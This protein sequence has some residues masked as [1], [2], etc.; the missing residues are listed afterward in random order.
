MKNTK[1][2]NNLKKTWIFTIAVLILFSFI[3]CSNIFQ[4]SHSEPEQKNSSDGK[5]YLVVDNATIRK[6]TSANRAASGNLGPNSNQIDVSK[7]TDFVLKGRIQS[8]GSEM[9]ELATA[10]TL[11]ELKSK[12]IMVEPA[13]WELILYTKLDGIPFHGTTY[14]TIEDGKENKIHFV[15]VADVDYGKLE[16]TVEWTNQASKV[17]AWLMD[18]ATQQT[19]IAHKV[20]TTFDSVQL[21]ESDGTTTAGHKVSFSFDKDINGQNLA[22]GTYYL[23]VDFDDV[24]DS[25]INK[26]EYFVNIAKGLTTKTTVR[27]DLSP[28]YSIT[29]N[30]GG[31]TLVGT[32]KPMNYNRRS[33]IILPE[34]KS[35]SKFFDGWYDEDGNKITGPIYGYSK[36]GPLTFTAQWKNPVLYVSGTGDDPTG[37]G[38]EANPYESIDKACETI[39][40]TGESEMDWVIYIMG[41]VTGPYRQNL[42]TNELSNPRKAGQ[43]MYDRDFGRSIIPE[44]LTTEHAKSIL[45]TGY[46]TPSTVNDYPQDIINRGL[47]EVSTYNGAG[48][49]LSIITQVP[50]TIT[51]VKLTNARN[52]DTN[53]N[54]AN[55]S[56]YNLGGG[57]G[58]GENATVYLGDN[59]YIEHNK[60]TYG[61]GIYNAGT[62]YI[63]GSAC[64]GDKTIQTVAD[65]YVNQ[66]DT[67]TGCFRSSNEYSQGGGIYNKG[68]LYLGYTRYVSATDND[69][70]L[71]TGGIYRSYGTTGGGIYITNNSTVVMN[72][73][74]IAYN[75]GV[76]SA[77][78]VY[79]DS[80]TFI[81]TGGTICHNST[82]GTGG[83]VKVD[84]N[85]VFYFGVEDPSDNPAIIGPNISANWATGNGGGIYIEGNSSTSRGKVFMFGKAVVGDK[86]KNT[87]P[88]S[89]NNANL[90]DGQNATNGGGGGIYVAGNLYMGYTRYNSGS[91]FVTSELNGGI[92]YNYTN[93]TSASSAGGGGIFL[94]DNGK[95]LMNSG[96]IANNVATKK[97]DALYVGGKGFVLGGTATI[98]AG[99]TNQTIYVL[100]NNFYLYIDNALAHVSNGS[101]RL[102]PQDNSW[103]NSDPTS[104]NTTNPIIVLTD[105][106]KAAGVTINDVKDKFTI[107]PFTNPTS[108]QVTNWTIDPE[109]GKTMVNTSTNISAS[110]DVG[111][112][113]LVVKRNGNPFANGTLITVT[114]SNSTVCLDFGSVAGKDSTT[115][116]NFLWVWDGEPF[117]RSN[118]PPGVT[119]RNSSNDRQIDINPTQMDYGIH[120]VGLQVIYN[121]QYYSFTCQ[122]KK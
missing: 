9:K 52:S 84:N 10:S 32:S 11:E 53:P 68:N 5:T 78:G 91:D 46:N 101:I 120:D 14:Q 111:G 34:M 75:D 4:K 36:S 60:A 100:T 23:S 35:N 12:K 29:Y 38:T 92:Y 7:L 44:T 48:P 64:I 40:E 112:A 21:Q 58:V 1:N 73:G 88:S 109:T 108:G 118:L 8:S 28:T 13:V 70:T 54:T 15:L 105:A 55:H 83:G 89:I 80:G 85:G 74:T 31:G 95:V 81:M 86:M 116:L 27:T 50:V 24:L 104:Y 2:M 39:I 94:A 79:I 122:I 76:S 103:N 25:N 59:V 56:F 30:D 110:L 41:D 99:N 22:S 65:S 98:P 121:G 6:T 106:A 51:N 113:D 77:G 61:G 19:L 66:T 67:T 33:I 43:R 72:S 107:E 97:G 17:S 87:A 90:S 16:I 114:G 93:A 37:D 82:G 71:W 62:L 57:L 102:L 63:Y 96:T 18:A 115:G 69:P 3:S 20:F 117:D 42:N 49:A 26:A 45:V 119:F 47:L